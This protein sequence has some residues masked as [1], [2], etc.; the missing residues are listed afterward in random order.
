MAGPSVWGLHHVSPHAVRANGSI[1]CV[2]VPLH[3]IGSSFVR[4]SPAGSL[5]TP[6]V[7]GWEGWLSVVP[8]VLWVC[9]E[10][11]SEWGMALHVCSWTSDTTC[12][13]GYVVGDRAVGASLVCGGC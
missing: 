1:A 10:R 13:K 2:H 11:A 5:I 4:T 7:G 9:S 8:L 6:L 12:S 3:M